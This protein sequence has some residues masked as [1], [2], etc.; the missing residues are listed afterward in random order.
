MESGWVCHATTVYALPSYSGRGNLLRSATFYQYSKQR[1]SHHEQ[2]HSLKDT[3]QYTSM[4]YLILSIIAST[5]IL[6]IF[7]SM[8]HFGANTRHS[9]TTSYL[10][11]AATG[12]F[13]FA[14][15]I[16]GITTP[17]FWPAAI[18]GAFFYF[19]FQ[20][21]ARTTQTNGVAV[22]SI[23]TKMS[24]VIPVCIGVLLLHESVTFFKVLGIMTGI[25]A[26][27]LSV[28]RDLQVKD[29]KW[30]LLVFLATGAIDSSFKL[31]QVWILTEQ[32]FPAFITTI[33]SFAF[34]TGLL[35]HLASGG[36]RIALNSLTSGVALGIAN[37]GTVYFVLKA[38]A[39]PQW[40]SSTIF[41]INNIGVV[42]L[43]TLVA[44]LV[45][46]ER[47]SRRGWIALGL[48]VLSIGLLFYGGF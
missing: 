14:P 2:A 11:S 5:L 17:W 27:L 31:F 20:L 32:Q 33:F 46:R 47:L 8:Q 10:V 25:V 26:V 3:V 29:W 19:V 48:A 16:P 38:L 24:V 15:E 35:H 21:M 22:A 34:I 7:R 45:F 36:G 23:A 39:Q 9:I 1:S 30:P 13:L 12:F 18:E 28:N 37:F 44:I 4:V 41:P 40:E 43:S 42:A 6:I